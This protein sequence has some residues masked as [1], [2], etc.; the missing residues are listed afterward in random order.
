MRYK[1]D[2]STDLD[3][4]EDDRNYQTILWRED[5][6]L[7]LVEY[8]LKTVTYG[9]ACSPFLALRVIQQLAIDEANNWPLGVNLLKRKYMDDFFFG[10]NDLK[11]L[12]KM[13]NE[14]IGVLGSAGMELG[15]WASNEISCLDGIPKEG[16]AEPGIIEVEDPSVLKTLGVLWNPKSDCFTFKYEPIDIVN[17]SKRN[18][19]SEASRC[20]DP[21]GWIS[22]TIIVLKIMF[23][24]TW[25]KKLSWDEELPPE[26]TEKWK[27][28][29]EKFNL[30]QE[31]TIPRWIGD[32]H[33]IELHGY[34]DASERAYAGV[35][36]S[37]ML[38]ASGKVK[39]R[40]L[41]AKTKVAPIKPISV[42]R[43]ELC[44]AHLLSKIIKVVLETYQ[45]FEPAVY[46]W[47]DSKIVLAWLSAHPRK[48][49]TFV[50]NRC[51]HIHE[52]C[53]K[54]PWNY[55]R[56][57]ENPADVASRGISPLDL[58]NCT[59]WWNGPLW[60]KD[61]KHTLISSTEFNTETEER[62][63]AVFLLRC[64]HS[65]WDEFIK[66]YSS[67]NRLRRTTA[68]ILRAIRCFKMKKADS[69]TLTADEISKAAFFL[70]KESQE[71][72][73]P[74]E[75]DALKNGRP[76]SRKSKLLQLAP[77]FDEN[78]LLRVGGRLRNAPINYETKHPVILPKGHLVEIII[79]FI[80][81]RYY[82][83][84][85][86]LTLALVRQFFWAIS[87]KKILR[88]RLRKCVE[89]NRY[90]GKTYSPEMGD[91]PEYRLN[92]TKPFENTGLDFAGPVIVRPYRG[93]GKI[94][95]KG[96]IAVF[97]CLVTRAINLELVTSLSTE[98]L[99]LAMKRFVAKRG[100]CKNIYSDNGR[101]FLG[102]S[103][104]L[105]SD[106]KF[107]IKTVEDPEISEFLL[108]N[109]IHWNFIPP[110][111]PHFG[112][113][114]EAGVKSV[115]RHLNRTFNGQCLTIEEMS[116]ALYEIEALLNSRPMA[117]LTD[118]YGDLG[119]LTPSHLLTGFQSVEVPIL[120]SVENTGLKDV[121]RY[122]NLK[123]LTEYFWKNWKQE[124]LQE[125]IKK[126]KWNKEGVSPELNEFVLIKRFNDPPCH[127]S[128]GRII[129]L[130]SGK[131]NI[132]R[133][134]DV[135]TSKGI[136]RESCRNLIPMYLKHEASTGE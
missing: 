80:H 17:F 27:S 83:S 13:R 63:P 118:D 113:I 125:L 38:D 4:N 40:L 133:V 61:F 134:V 28:V 120:R 101:N 2:V 111:S 12:R 91:L 122:Q 29:R 124:F 22:P 79:D 32:F 53:P 51:G 42:A 121:K 123:S 73:F 33:R 52:L 8:R 23:Q 110:Y 16:L 97:I 108:N 90:G 49:T 103:R 65:F 88:S 24:A 72:E 18:L 112:G 85:F 86:K 59:L 20:F 128:K 87:L 107:I 14:L 19:L 1:E 47:T 36:Y 78:K 9:E 106:R 43:L 70:I 44:G 104:Q 3:I 57:T 99:I 58:I 66:R 115:K 55:V 5:R 26:L 75:I 131:D 46:C 50:S 135:L 94:S 93:K 7:P 77:F 6:N 127:W 89:C 81:L 45:E 102:C 68:W 34:C 39:I 130:F 69:K 41:M 100:Q 74:G 37:R 116:T 92:I 95:L 132:V 129:K 114:W 48:W 31:V 64:D 67:F 56:T 21:F 117:P 30:F 15:K 76:L 11:T 136:H 71:R 109:L 62:N 84:G 126:S 25:I 60:L 105:I 98:S 54:I 10:H 82:H 96:Y 35:V 119:V